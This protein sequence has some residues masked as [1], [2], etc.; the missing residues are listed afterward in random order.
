MKRRATGILAIIAAL[1]ISA[2]GSARAAANSKPNIILF[3]VDDLGW[4]GPGCYGS[5]LH[6]TPHVDR[7]AAEGVRFTNAYAASPV[8]TPTRASIQTGL[9]PARLHMTIWRESATRVGEGKRLLE[10]VCEEDLKREYLSVADLLKGAGY[11][12]AHV[13]KWHLGTVEYFPEAHGYDIS[14]GGNIWGAPDSFFHPYRGDETFRRDG[15]RYVP[16]IGFSRPG[17]YL[18]DKLTDAAVEVI[19][20]AGQEPFYLQLSYYTTHTPIEGKAEDVEHFEGKVTPQSQ[21]RNTHYAAMHKSLDESVGRVLAKLDQRGLTERTVVFFLSD[22]GGFVGKFGGEVVTTNTP[23]R[24]G[25]GS[26]YEGGLRIPWIV[27]WPGRGASGAVC[28]EPVIT[29]DL[30]PTIADMTGTRDQLSAGANTVDGVS[31]APLLID[32]E[33]KLEQRDLHFHYPHY[34][35][36]TSPVS[37]IRSGRWKLLH[38]YEDRHVELYDLEKDPGEQTDLSKEEHE[39]AKQLGARLASWSHRIKAQF[40]RENRAFR[41]EK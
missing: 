3:L 35:H 39:R 25:K 11:L 29:T 18:T 32:P 14:I 2:W 26:L 19:E 36:T 7:L 23:L 37:A 34:Y 28:D 13:G 21:H 5:D 30:L 41:E 20:F 15:F 24:S 6:E 8:C 33:S 10:P 17:D 4:T 12:T 31:I 27:R 9:H 1:G 40:P 38:Y 16:G 22:N